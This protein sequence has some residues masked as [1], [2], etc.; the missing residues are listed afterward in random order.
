MPKRKV[1]AAATA[2]RAT[3]AT[4]ATAAAAAT[5]ATPLH[6]N[7]YFLV[8]SHV[9]STP[10]L[11]WS[12]AIGL[13][14]LLVLYSSYLDGRS[15]VKYTDVDYAVFT[16]AARE[17]WAGGSPYDRATYRYTPLLAWALVPNLA[18]PL[19]GKF[20]FCGFDVAIGVLLVRILRLRGVPAAS[21]AGYAA[22][23][24]LH[25]MVVNVS[26]RGNGD[27]IVCALVLATLYC[28]LTRRE[29]GAAVAFGAA[30]HV[31]IFPIIYVVPFWLFI[32]S[33]RGRGEATAV[34]TTTDG[35]DGASVRGDGWG[36]LLLSFSWRRL[37]FGVI[38]A[39]VFGA[40]TGGCYAAYG[41]TMLWETYLYHF[42]R[43]DNRHNF[44]SYFYD[45]YLSPPSSQQGDAGGSTA[46]IVFGAGLTAV[47]RL[48]P[49][50]G[51]VVAT[52]VMLAGDPPAALF[53]QTFAFVA[54][55]RV[56]TAQ[57]FHWWL[58]LLPLVLPASSLGWVAGAGLS[59]LWLLSELAWLLPAFFLE[60]RG[61][62]VFPWVWAQG[63]LRVDSGIVC[64]VPHLYGRMLIHIF[65][66]VDV[67]QALCFSW[68]TLPCCASSL[69]TTGCTIGREE[70]KRLNE[71]NRFRRNKITGPPYAFAV[72]PAPSVRSTSLH[73]HNTTPQKTL[74]SMQSQKRTSP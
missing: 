61:Q 15:E 65:P 28:L 7:W 40:L 6:R 72:T 57:Y 21:A 3:A 34:S 20:L 51:A 60:L 26:T 27:S 38:S 30:V 67:L 39:T 47:L 42:V 5:S 56:V 49:Q 10:T 23:F 31:K 33:D 63:E 22:A 8:P 13:R 16:D 1:A 17:V 12:A 37:R 46:A 44:S 14:I 55:N 41:F 48:L 71:I 18:F 50:W 2:V 58:S 59:G 45:A 68:P 19:W 36:R 52:G 73:V 32:D 4:A 70:A 74:L 29:V 66:S 11:V 43:S 62:A 25:P 54:L 64:G 24:L 53:V 9:P 35:S 69:R